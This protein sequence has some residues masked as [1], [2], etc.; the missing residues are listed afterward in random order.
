MNV[1]RTRTNGAPFKGTGIFNSPGRVI[2]GTNRTGAALFLWLL[3]IIVGLC[4]VHVYIEY[5]LNVPRYV[6]YGV[7]QPVPRSGGDL[8]YV[9]PSCPPPNK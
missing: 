8:H 1:R 3:G 4:G 9:G 2:A 7:E 5:G 6:I